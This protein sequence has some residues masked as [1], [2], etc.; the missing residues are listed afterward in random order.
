MLTKPLQSLYNHDGEL[1]G[2]LLSPELWDQV[3]DA[4][5]PHLDELPSASTCG[6]KRAKSPGQGPARPLQRILPEPMED[7]QTLVDYWDFR[8][9]VTA[10]AHCE[11]CGAATEDWT[12]DEPRKFTLKACNLGGLVALECNA[13]EA[14]I[15]KRHFKDHITYDCKPCE[16]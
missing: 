9:P 15:T 5:L 2:V 3:K 13:C 14:R 4:I 10:E 1:V 8:Y 12:K 16:G 11:H 7:W 6:A